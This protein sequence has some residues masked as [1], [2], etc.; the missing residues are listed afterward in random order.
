M[1]ILIPLAVI[2]LCIVG[3]CISSALKAT[4]WEAQRLGDALVAESKRV[5]AEFDTL[6]R[7]AQQP[8]EPRVGDVVWRETYRME[9]RHK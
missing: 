5:Q 7:E 4:C 2:G 9:T 8:R 6:I 1:E 3:M